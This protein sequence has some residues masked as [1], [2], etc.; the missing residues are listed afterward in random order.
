VAA[1]HSEANAAGWRLRE[2]GAAD[3]DAAWALRRRAL[4]E[5]PTA[6]GSHL[7]ELPS[8]PAYR[9][10]LE[11]R[12]RTQAQRVVGAFMPDATGEAL[13]GVVT[14]VR[15]S[16]LKSRHRADL[17][18]LYVAPEARRV[19]VGRALVAAAVRAASELG[20]ERFELTVTAD[21]DGARRLYDEAGFRTWGVQPSAIRVD[22]RYLD[23]AHM[24]LALPRAG[25]PN[26]EYGPQ[27]VVTE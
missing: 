3:D 25:K 9:A 17:Y 13:V 11:E 18:G 6:F 1:T 5:S 27:S 23:E 20:A 2:L 19:G 12:R 22:G 7:D 8:L 24:A 14:V 21:N 16:R 4:G 10:L 26:G 15:A